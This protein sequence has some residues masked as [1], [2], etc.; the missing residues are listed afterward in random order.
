[1]L[2]VGILVTIPSLASCQTIPNP[3]F[4]EP[5]LPPGEARLFP[6]S[7]GYV[8][9]IPALKWAFGMPGGICVEGL[10]YAEG[11]R[12][13]DGKQ[14]AVIQGDPRS[15]NDYP[16]KSIMGVDVTGL[17]P[18]KSYEISWSQTGRATDL[19]TC[20]ITV[21]LT[22]ENF[23]PVVLVAAEKV[24]VHGKWQRIKKEFLAPT[25]KLRLN[26]QHTILESKNADAGSESTLFD[27]FKIKLA[28]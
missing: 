21:T 2:A 18:G 15:P 8:D 10:E 28:E 1:M 9:K 13:V 5:V 17:E 3:S 16:I 23:P 7:P 24:E 20:A 4:E 19:G 11:I 14:V 6:D 22:A 12:A 27:D 26:I 25:D